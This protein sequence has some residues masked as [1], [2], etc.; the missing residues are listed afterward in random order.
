MTPARPARTGAAHQLAALAE[1]ALG[2]PLPL[3]LRAWDGSETGP[4]DG[5]VVV[6]RT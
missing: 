2:G 6:V 3:R 5:P 1:E 4:E